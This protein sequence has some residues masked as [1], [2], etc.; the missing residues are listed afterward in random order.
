M[1][2]ALDDLVVYGE[3]GVC[4]I[5]DLETRLFLGEDRE[6]YKLMPLYQSCVIFTPVEN[7]NVFIRSVITTEEANYILENEWAVNPDFLTSASPRMLAE[8]YDK[9][10]K[11][12]DCREM[13]TFI[14]SI[15]EKRRLA[16]ESKRN[17]R[18]W[19]KDI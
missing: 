4:R 17:C 1:K 13:M 3:T 7:S 11:S 16:I 12:H 5:V 6:C 10:I 14:V 18:P 8:K 2:F 9:I 19:M 15:Y